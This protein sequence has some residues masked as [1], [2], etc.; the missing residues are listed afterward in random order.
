MPHQLSRLALRAA[1]FAG[2]AILVV[3]AVAPLLWILM[4]SFKRDVDAFAYPP[5]FFFKPTLQHYVTLFTT[6]LNSETQASMLRSF[7]NSLIVTVVSTSLSLAIACS[8][9][10]S[11]AR[12]RPKGAGLLTVFILGVRMLPPIVLVAPMF[13]IMHRLDLMDTLLALI[14]PYTALNIP[15]ATWMM[16]SFFLDLPRQ[17]EEAA[18]VDGC[19]PLSA[20][21]RVIL[22]LAAPGLGATAIFGFVLAWN[23][24]VFALPLTTFDAVTLPVIASRARVEEGILWGQLGAVASVMTLPVI[25]FTFVLQKHIV[26]GLTAGA[27]KG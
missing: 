21:W 25:L 17:L 18:L 14:I 20:F 15:L 13:Q 26:K 22:P 16:Y 27:V 1:L 9:G 4:T 8:A 10:Y 12:L 3:F 24:L 6:G 5:L 19:T 2:V 11:L 23:D 7:W